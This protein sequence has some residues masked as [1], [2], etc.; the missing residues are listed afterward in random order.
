MSD[1]TL[2]YVT[3]YVQQ[4]RDRIKKETAEYYRKKAEENGQVIPPSDTRSWEEKNFVDNDKWGTMDNG[5]ATIWYIIIMVGGAI[6][7]DRWLIWIITTIIYFNHINRKS[8][9]QKKWD[10]MQ[11]EKKNGGNKQ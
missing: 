7:N 3:E 10:K 2:R 8:I 6:F 9:R 11:G 5:T 1:E 4:E